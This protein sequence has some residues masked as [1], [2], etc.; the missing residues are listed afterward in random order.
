MK[1]DL[2][3]PLIAPSILAADWGNLYRE[4]LRMKELGA[5]LLHIDVMDGVFV[6]NISIGVMVQKYLMDNEIPI[7]PFDTHLMVHEPSY[8]LEQCKRYKSLYVTVHIES[9]R[10]I[11]RLVQ[12]IREL[13]MRPGISLNPGTNVRIL[14]DILPFVDLVLVMSVNPG[15]G[16]QKMITQTLHKIEWLCRERDKYSYSYLIQVDGGIKIDNIELAWEKGADIIVSGS[17]IFQTN[18]KNIIEEMKN[19]YR[20]DGIYVKD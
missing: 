5:D 7:L 4:T 17:G 12:N 20:K 10:H 2:K 13:G 14:E 6:P 18:R 19:K 1:N 3:K 11:H 15:F 9:A 8:L 16:G